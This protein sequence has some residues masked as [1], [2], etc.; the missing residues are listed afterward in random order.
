[1][2]CFL[3]LTVAIYTT[4]STTQVNPCHALFSIVDCSHLHHVVHYST[5]HILL[6]WLTIPMSGF[7]FI[8]G[9]REVAA[10][11]LGI[12]PPPPLEI[13][14][15]KFIIDVD[16]CLT[17]CMSSGSRLETNAISMSL[18]SNYF[19]CMDISSFG[20]K[21]LTIRYPLCAEVRKQWLP[22]QIQFLPMI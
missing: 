5:Y 13:V 14:L 16:K 11:P 21:E 7:H 15:L 1:M 4:L 8:L 20:C 6:L 3:L 10:S 19:S 22:S 12:F 2:P 17:K 9:S 18:A